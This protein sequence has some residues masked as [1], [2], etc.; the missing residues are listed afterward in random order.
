MTANP[1]GLV[2]KAVALLGAGFLILYNRSETVRGGIA[3]I[4]EAMKQL[5]SNMKDIASAF[6]TGDFTALVS[7]FRNIGNGVGESFTQG[8]KE[9]LDAEKVMKEE[10]EGV[11]AAVKEGNK[12]LTDEEKAASAAAKALEDKKQL[13]RQQ[14]LEEAN[15]KRLAAQRT[16]EDLRHELIEDSYERERT[17]AA[18]KFER[19]IEDLD[20][21]AE[22][23]LERK[24]LIEENKKLVLDELK[25]KQKEEDEAKKLEAYEL[26]LEEEELAKEKELLQIE[27]AFITAVDAEQAKEEAIY[28]VQK[29]YAQKRYDLMVTM[30]G[31]DSIQALKASNA[32]LNIEKNRT[33]DLLANE[34][35]F[36]NAKRELRELGHQAVVDIFHAGLALMDEESKLRKATAKAL[37]AYT[38]GKMLID[39]QQEIAALWKNNNSSPINIVAPGYGAIKSIAETASVVA[40]TAVGI[41]QVRAQKFALGGATVPM[42]EV[43]GVWQQARNAGSFSPGGMVSG[44]NL[45]VIGEKGPE[46]VAPNWMLQRPDTANVIGMLEATRKGRAFAQGGSTSIGQESPINMMG[47]DM[48]ALEQKLDLNNQLL[49]QL[50]QNVTAWPATLKVMNSLQE[51]EDGLRTLQTIRDDASVS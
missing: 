29:E 6:L 23:Y 43:D 50:N 46:W 35:A 2:L 34:Q 17:K 18:A 48:R 51:V 44:T 49:I 21:N 1:I 31:K 45:G 41:K 20:K 28:N 5:G 30:H 16:L 37:K 40:R 4:W 14:A 13:A 22:T 19:E 42:V 38:I 33:K 25:A 32:L 11:V 26:M 15:K 27:N 3:G 36:E 9:K 24:L 7:A 47:T 12:Q 8:Y 10:Q 39:A